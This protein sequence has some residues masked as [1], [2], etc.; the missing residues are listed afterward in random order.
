MRMLVVFVVPVPMLVL[1]Y[2]VR[3][4]MLMT[5]RQ[6]QPEANCH[7]PGAPQGLCAKQR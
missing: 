7:K 3:M 4:V 6:V 2:L 5:F 1:H